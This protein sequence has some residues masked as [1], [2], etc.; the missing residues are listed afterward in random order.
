MYTNSQYLENL[1][2]YL[3]DDL[4]PRILHEPRITALCE[5]CTVL[6]ALMVLDV[7]VIPDT[8]VAEELDELS[9]DLDIGKPK[10]GLDRL[11]ISQLLQMVLQ[12]AQTRLFF[13]AQSLIQSDI[14]LFN[15]K[16]EDL[17]YPEILRG[18]LFFIIYMRSNHPLPTAAR[19]PASSTGLREKESVSQMFRLSSIDKEDT[20][21]PALQK[22][23]W[24]LSQLHD[25][26]KVWNELI[27][28]VIFR[29]MDFIACDIRRHSSGGRRA[30]SPIACVCLGS[31][32]AP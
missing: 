27:P 14:R 9:I 2:D 25:F 19:Q 8:P 18:A 32:K 10:K 6:Q 31:D 5:V 28:I 23:V 30:L 13:K 11:H 20:W 7:S 16:P 1:C 4:R 15:P 3:Y 21:Y 22:T 17:N 26:V 29:P 24:I 12:D